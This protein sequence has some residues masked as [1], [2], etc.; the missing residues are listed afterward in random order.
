MNLLCSSSWRRNWV[1]GLPDFLCSASKRKGLGRGGG[2]AMQDRRENFACW[3][4]TKRCQ[5]R[6]LTTQSRSITL[7]FPRKKAANAAST[8]IPS[9]IVF[10]RIQRSSTSWDYELRG[11]HRD[12]YHA[13][14]KPIEND[15]RSAAYASRFGYNPLFL[16]ASHKPRSVANSSYAWIFIVF[17]LK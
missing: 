13:A 11:Y 2:P 8:M 17:L 15:I 10:A 6:G 7:T 16:L 9:Y 5:L 12:Q 14:K 3:V 1:T 4:T